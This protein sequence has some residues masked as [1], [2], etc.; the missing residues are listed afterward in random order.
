ML[1]QEN[2]HA[3]TVQRPNCT[4]SVVVTF[5]YPRDLAAWLSTFHSNRARLSFISF[6]YNGATKCMML[7]I[8]S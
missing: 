4:F 8:L 1:L 3:E 2:K 5:C 7:G 6:F